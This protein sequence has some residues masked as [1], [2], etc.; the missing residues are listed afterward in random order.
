MILIF[1]LYHHLLPSPFS[2]DSTRNLI[3]DPLLNRADKASVK[4]PLRAQEASITLEFR[5]D[6]QIFFW[7][8][9]PN[10]KR[11]L[12]Q[13]PNL[14]TCKLQYINFFV[15]G[16]R[17]NLIFVLTEQKGDLKGLFIRQRVTTRKMHI[18]LNFFS[19]SSFGTLLT[20][21]L[22]QCRVNI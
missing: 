16:F 17:Y 5:Q 22:H 10:L 14:R 20:Y 3:T 19:A 4:G 21:G 18:N 11:K 2:S 7:I 8:I 12:M 9:L 6:Q 1:L 13:L 15:L